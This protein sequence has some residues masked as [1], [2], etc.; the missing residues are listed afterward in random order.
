MGPSL[1]MRR[2]LA[3][4][5]LL[6]AAFLPAHAQV[7]R[8]PALAAP[9]VVSLAAPLEKA[10]APSVDASG[11]LR[12]ADVRAL[13][14][15]AAV[16]QWR[17]A[18]GGFV[19]RFTVTSSGASGLRVRLDLSEVPGPIEARVS[20]GD[21]TIE[22]T[23]IDPRNGP[24]AWTA[25]TAGDTQVIEV[26]SRVRPWDGAVHVG[27]VLHFTES[28][29][30]KAAGTCTV[31]VTCTT[32]DSTLDAAIA[33]AKKAVMR[34]QFIDG[35]G[36][37]VCTATLIDTPQRPAPFVMTANHCINTAAS[38]GTITTWWFYEN[39]ATCDATS[40]STHTQ[41]S[42]GMQL[43]F[44]NHELDGSLLEMNASPPAGAYY[45]PINASLVTNGQAMVSLSHPA[46][47]AMRLA[48]GAVDKPDLRITDNVLPF[49]SVKYSRGIIE[50]GSSGS[51]LFV[52]DN[53]TL[54]FRGTLLGTT[55]DN[56]GA[57]M[58][59]S[60]TNELAIYS[61]FDMFAEE[62]A[63][64][65]GTT[66]VAGDDAPNRPADLAASVG[67]VLDTGPFARDGLRIDYG[68]DLDTFKFTLLQPAVVSAWTEG[69]NLDTVGAI[70]DSGGHWIDSN[71]DAQTSS[72]HFGVSHALGAGTYFVQVGHF[73]PGGTGGYNLRVRA[74][75]VDATNYSDIWYNASESGWGININ[76]QDNTIFASLYTYDANGS[77]LWLAMSNGQRQPDGSYAG[78]LEQYSG[79]AYNAAWRASAP[80]VVGTMRLAFSSATTGTL[81][82]TY[83]GA[84]VT[85]SISRYVFA[86]AVSCKWS[87]FDRSWATN[88]QDLWFDPDEPGW[89]LNLAHE[90]DTIFGALFT[91]DASG[92]PLWLVMS[93]SS[94]TAY[95]KYSG[96]L[97]RTTGPA[98]N[99]S[100][101]T[102]ATSTAVGTMSLDFTGTLQGQA[103]VLGNQGTLTYTV[104]GVTVRK[105]IQRYAYGA[106]RPD[107]SS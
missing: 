44:G 33:Q 14:K 41:V 105:P 60:D 79:S 8:A 22:T 7:F 82:Y 6:A 73:E 27:A 78:N 91:Y 25:W 90:G 89:G 107:C 37:Y 29:F 15:A 40:P 49:V 84:T 63:Q 72:N 87:A 50:G 97:A 96:T 38:A 58:S 51:G 19:S 56:T 30:L 55:V 42:G 69:A 57:G 75:R 28:P 93:G 99:A 39:S 21:A 85:K 77:P 80:S 59:C 2:S 71:D 98:F 94:M 18:D 4:A 5:A 12:V 24:E 65:T 102:G 52:M 34:I 68:G 32:N 70:L 36:G 103:T 17:A 11:R 43:V 45:A 3:A 54:Q 101:W 46:G 47:D 100:P 10:A 95:G 61:R 62:M 66:K 31:P 35:G 83:N 76:H 13:D 81:T 92:K 64:Y 86:K 53:G 26:F 48:I 20:G 16:P 23:A 74:D 9:R 1:P 67:T 106:L 104:D 88:Y